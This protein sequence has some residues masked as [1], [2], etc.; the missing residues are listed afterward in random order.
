MGGIERALVVLAEY[1]AERG[2]HV[3]FI[4]CLSGPHFYKLTSGINLI[5]LK[6]KH[7]ERP[8]CKFIFYIRVIFSLRRTIIKN[9]PDVV[10]VFGDWFSPLVLFSLLGLTIP[11]FISDR[12][13]P[14][15]RFKF[16]LPLFKKWLYPRSAGFIAQTKRAAEFKHKQFGNKLNIA[17][18]P[19]ALREVFLYPDIKREK[20][21]LYVGRFAWEKGPERLISAF[22]AI[23]DK[24]NWKLHMAGSGTELNRMKELV[25]GMNI[26]DQV[27]FHGQVKDIDLLYAKAGIYVLPSYLEGF[28]NSL[29][30][31]MAAGLPCICFD[32]IPHN[33]ILTDGLDGI[34]VKNDDINA[35]TVELIRLIND[36]KL[37]EGLSIQA[38]NIRTRLNIENI[39]KKVI[40]FL[41]ND[42]EYRLDCVNAN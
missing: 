31:A 42:G 20:I 41:F 13:S 37:R 8:L 23:P 6:F 25:H 4:S 1:F 34:V 28:P 36:K 40:D 38:L 10:L 5:E 12:T 35:L 14:D 39:G 29:C 9:I 30:E 11:V 22:K 16:P 24:K 15:Y 21:I 18:I 3:N 33:E 32:S 7:S 27:I 19:N 2:H 17:V 26:T